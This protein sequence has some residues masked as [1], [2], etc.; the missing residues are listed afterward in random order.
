MTV[1]TELSAL[2]AT[3]RNR[4]HAAPFLAELKRAG[5]TD[6]QI[7][8]LAPNGKRSDEVEEDTLAGALSGGLL[9]AVAGAVAS[10]LIPGIGPVI[11]SGLL[12]GVLGGAAVGATAGGVLGAL[13][14][15]GVPEAEARK[16]E[17]ELLAGRTLVV[18]QAEARGGEALAILRR[19]Q[20][21]LSTKEGPT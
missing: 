3:F 15:L 18:V 1:K 4:N 5:F 16:H 11:A 7:G 14:G 10:G 9:G 17:Q 6:D 19:C 8:V 20:R 21:D 13:I 2:I 12:A